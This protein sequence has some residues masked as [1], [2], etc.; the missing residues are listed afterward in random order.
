MKGRYFSTTELEGGTACG[1]IGDKLYNELFPSQ[2]NPV[3]TYVFYHG[4][5][6]KIIG[7][8]K[9]MGQLYWNLNLK[10]KVNEVHND[11]SSWWCIILGLSFCSARVMK[12]GNNNL[13][14]SKTAVDDEKGLLGF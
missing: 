8:L 14:C 9:K 11:Y 10:Y 1:V 6:I 4:K 7:L 12:P 5:K 3:G 13:Y 2:L